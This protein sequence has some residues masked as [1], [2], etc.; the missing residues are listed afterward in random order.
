MSDSTNLLTV[1]TAAE[2]LGLSVACLRAWV[3]RRKIGYVKVGARR[4][5]IPEAEI[6][7]IIERGFVPALPERNGR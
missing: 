4:I 7:K 1:R 2:R 5:A 6:A 3:M